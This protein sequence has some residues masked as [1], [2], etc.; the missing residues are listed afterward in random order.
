MRRWLQPL[1]VLVCV[2]GA[3]FAL[4]QARLFAPAAVATAGPVAL[5]DVYQ[6][7]TVFQQTCAAC[8]GAAGAGGGIGPRLQS[9]GI[10]PATIQARIRA[11]AGAMPPA[12]VSGRAEADIVAYVASIAAP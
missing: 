4:A 12:L 8:H 5:G 9:S 3:V 2:S 6:G 1:V 7:E 10:T 11:G